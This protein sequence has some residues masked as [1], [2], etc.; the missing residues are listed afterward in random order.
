LEIFTYNPI[1]VGI[2]SASTCHCNLENVIKY[3][4][5]KTHCIRREWRHF[6]S[7]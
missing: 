6:T 2:I 1:A 4:C 3:V 7:I 5:L